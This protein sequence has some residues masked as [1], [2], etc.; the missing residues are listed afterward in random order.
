MARQRIQ[1][2][3]L[4][5]ALGFGALAV[6]LAMAVALIGG[7]AVM[8]GLQRF[9]TIGQLGD[10]SVERLTVWGDA[11]HLP[12][13]EPMRVLVGF[14]PDAQQ[15]VLERGEATV[16]LTQNQQW[17]RAHNVVLDAW[18]TGGAL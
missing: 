10:S 1:P 17:D 16:R 4:E 6:A 9:G 3:L 12:F 13:T 14:G 2:S 8:T 11:L 7:G 5:F 18:L 15:S